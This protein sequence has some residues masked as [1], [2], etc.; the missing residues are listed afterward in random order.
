MQEQDTKYRIT[1]MQGYK[2][3]NIQEHDTR[4]QEYNVFTLNYMN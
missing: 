2:T 3:T 4:K 1:R